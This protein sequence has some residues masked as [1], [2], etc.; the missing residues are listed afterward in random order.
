MKI[1]ISERTLA[2]VEQCLAIVVLV[3]ASPQNGK[4]PNVKWRYVGNI[5]S[6]R[7]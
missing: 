3:C 1:A 5:Y 2:I 4:N 6:F 7:E